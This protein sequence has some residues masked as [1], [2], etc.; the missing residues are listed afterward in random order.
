MLTDSEAIQK[1]MIS[2]QGRERHNITQRNY[3]KQSYGHANVVSR[4]AHTATQPIF[5]KGRSEH[6]LSLAT[7]HCSHT[8]QNESN[9]HDCTKQKVRVDGFR[10]D[11]EGNDW[12]AGAGET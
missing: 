10:S 1:A 6:G 3:F 12:C 4:A 11:S 5:S 2:V 8:M 7:C 9:L